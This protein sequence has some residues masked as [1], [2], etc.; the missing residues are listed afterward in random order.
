MNNHYQKILVIIALLLAIALISSPASA[1]KVEG[2]KIMIDVKPG[3]NYI[4]PM[5]VS[6]KET[7]SPSDYAIDILGFGQT[8]EGGSYQGL[9]A[10]EDASPYSARSY[11]SVPESRIHLEPGERKAFDATIRI[12]ENI[13]EGGRYAIILIHP[14]TTG[15]EQA[16][17][18]T[19]VAVP[20]MLT[21]QGTKTIETGTI[22]DVSAGQVVAGKPIMIATTL[23]NT[24]NHHYYGAVNTL[25][26]KDAGGNT[27]ATATSEPFS[28]AVIP[29]MS[30]RFETPI[31]TGLSTGTYTV[32]SRMTLEDGT[33]LDEKSTT[34]TVTE[35]Y[36]PPFED[37]S[38]QLTPDKQA[39][40]A[41]SDGSIS[42]I[43]PQGAVFGDAQVTLTPYT[44]TLPSLPSGVSAGNTAFSVEGL[45]GLL[46]KPATV[47]VR[48]SDQDLS[49]AGGD[50]SKLTIARWDRSENKWTL[51]QTSVDTANRKLSATSDRF[52]IMAVV[53]SGNPP[54]TQGGIAE[55]TLVMGVGIAVL[56]VGGKKY[57]L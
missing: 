20:V 46:S 5:A 25:T 14:A 2:A 54:P 8:V 57:L 21:V 53:A 31:T 19:A 55:L 50:A 26:V 9:P 30:V 16:S 39:T 40:L 49:A 28:R 56:L 7:D 38:I 48:Y 45:T 3:T 15:S 22:T 10:G 24:G 36:I 35:E 42:I 18:A 47:T 41:T 27:V 52:G 32:T 6:I 1:L 43:F 34:F 33:L 29:T 17:F 12:P 23:S 37:V 51:L 11:I 44:A 4:F 13:G